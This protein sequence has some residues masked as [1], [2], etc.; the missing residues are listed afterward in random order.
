M[1]IIHFTLVYYSKFQ[2]KKKIC[3]VVGVVCLYLFFHINH[4]ISREIK[5]KTELNKAQQIVLSF[6]V[7]SH[8]FTQRYEWDRTE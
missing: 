1:F 5:L 8:S 6:T 3:T 7:D 2:K 4:S